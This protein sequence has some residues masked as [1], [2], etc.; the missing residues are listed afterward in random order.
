[1]TPEEIRKVKDIQNFVARGEELPE[2]LLEWAVEFYS[3]EI[4]YNYLTGED[5]DP[6]EWIADEVG[7]VEF[8]VYNYDFSSKGPVKVFG[9]AADALAFLKELGSGFIMSDCE[10][11]ASG[12]TDEGKFSLEWI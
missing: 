7:A 8:D 4:P 3:D 6:E 11:M 2:A 1:M 10:V 12:K 5:G 9:N